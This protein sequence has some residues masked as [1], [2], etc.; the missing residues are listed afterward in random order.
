MPVFAEALLINGTRKGMVVC[1]AEDLDEISCAG[2]TICA[3]LVVQGER[4]GD[5]NWG[6][7]GNAPG[8][9]T[10]PRAGQGDATHVD[11]R[12]EVSIEHFVLKPRHF[13]LPRH[14]LSDVSPGRTAD[15]NAEILGRLLR[16]KMGPEDPILHFVLMNAAAL[17]VVAGAAEAE[18]CPFGSGE[19]VVGERGP[20]GGRWKEGVRLARLAIRTGRA[21]EMLVRFAEITNL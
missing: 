7:E 10:V 16:G 18:T 20:G 1:G 17:F 6:E 12:G 9:D 2:D 14:A 3:R 8:A 19:V 13:G 11:W 4:D 15:E 5:P 21:M